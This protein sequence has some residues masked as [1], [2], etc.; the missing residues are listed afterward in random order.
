MSAH[1]TYAFIV[2]H[3]AAALG[4]VKGLRTGISSPLSRKNSMTTSVGGF[5]PRSIPAGRLWPIGLDQSDD[6][7]VLPGVPDFP[8]LRSGIPCW[9]CLSVSVKWILW[10]VC[11]LHKHRY[12]I[13]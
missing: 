12:A 13:A 6:L 11:R 2:Q 1:A 9:H 4:V 7:P 3:P 10:H 5:A 8:F